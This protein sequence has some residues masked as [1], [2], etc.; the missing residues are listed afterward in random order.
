MGYFTKWGDGDYDF[1]PIADLT[2]TEIYE[3]L[4]Y[5]K[6]PECVFE[7]PPSGGLYEGQTDEKDLGISYKA[8]D[9]YLLN[10]NATEEDKALI[11]RFHKASAHKR[12]APPVYGG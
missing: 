2:V 6:A 8:I 12:K 11:D 9:D 5:L 3:F 4:R 10:G 7:K 1:N